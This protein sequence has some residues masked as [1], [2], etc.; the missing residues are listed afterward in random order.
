MVVPPDVWAFKN[1]GLSGPPEVNSKYYPTFVS[2]TNQARMIQDSSHTP[3]GAF[4]YLLSQ[5]TPRP[6]LTVAT[7]FPT[8]DDTVSCAYNSVLAHCPD[9]GKIGEQV[10]WSFDNMVISVLGKEIKQMRGVVSNF[11]WSPSFSVPTDANT[12]K[13]WKYQLDAENNIQYDANGNPIKVGDPLAQID[14]QDVIPPSEDD[15]KIVNYRD[16]G[17]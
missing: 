8:A 9:I 17:Y 4:G 10:T 2:A 16:D 11:G 15:G 13:Y 6:K 1:M 14:W 7:H 5:I 3:Q 12:A